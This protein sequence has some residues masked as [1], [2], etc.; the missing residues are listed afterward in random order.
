MIRSTF[1]GLNTMVSGVQTSRLS[2]ETVGHNISNTNT[3][4]YSRQSANSVAVRGSQIYTTIGPQI[5][6]N[7]TDVASITRARDIYAD[8]QYWKENA[9]SGYFDSR[10]TNY[11]K[12]EVIFND[13]DDNGI[14]NALE[15]FYKSWS[16]VS[17]QASTATSRQTVISKG[18]SYATRIQNAA[19]QVQ[20]QISSIYD[21]M[22][23]NLTS[24][25]SMTD[26]IAG[27]NRNIM[28][29]EA[30]GASANDLRDQR[31]A[32]VDKL[33][34]MMNISIYEDSSGMYNVVSNGT[35]L[36]NGVAKID[37]ELSEPIPSKVYGIND[38][39]IRIKQT[40]T[41][42][43]PGT[44]S[45]QA[46]LDSI[47]EDKNFL[48]YLSNMAA[49]C[50]TTLNAQHRAGA[51]IDAA[52]STGINFYGEDGFEYAWNAKKNCVE[53]RKVKVDPDYDDDTHKLTSVTFTEV[54]D[55]AET[56]KNGDFYGI[57]IIDELVVNSRLTDSADGQKYLATRGLTY[58]GYYDEKTGDT[59]K[60]SKDDKGNWIA[61]TNLLDPK[62][63]R[64]GP[65]ETYST[66]YIIAENGI[67]GTGDGSVAVLIS[68]LFNCVQ[69]LTAS[70]DEAKSH[71]TMAKHPDNTRAIG[72]VSLFSYYNGQMT[73]MGSRAE[74]MKHNVDFQD[75]VMTQVSNL[76]ESTSGVNWDEE[77]T[78]M[79][80]FQQGYGACSRC[81]TTMDEMLD[82]LINGT[83][84]V[85]R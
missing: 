33:S 7:G 18:Q 76:R 71:F 57:N 25:N 69:S 30:G 39:S 2:L 78:N 23:L 55:P 10:Y 82:K 16:E 83:G 24:I 81:L 34:N 42:Y 67:N 22:E 54:T 60:C 73:T 28:V 65:P 58:E 13:T 68:N 9:N 43:S 75:N 35:T 47:T 19:K 37:L 15:D 50:L 44:G 21:D 49:F 46:Q 79:I 41:L 52:T 6:G 29:Q 38:F 74:A 72:T 40:G 64:E 5:I 85:G 27:L 45:L 32:L 77:L 56:K 8:R 17:T 53:K 4:G 12:L 48:G 26:Q 1:A 36:V 80:M 84:T 20:E 62:D 59:V 70:S 14:Q 63:Y 31:D 66:K 61:T 3:E 51:G 11:S